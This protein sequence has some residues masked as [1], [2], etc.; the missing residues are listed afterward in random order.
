M[1]GCTPPPLPAG[2]DYPIGYTPDHHRAFAAAGT[3]AHEAPVTPIPEPPGF[4]K[5]P[6]GSDEP[7]PASGSEQIECRAAIRSSAAPRGAPRE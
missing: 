5:V 2:P 1:T 3:K 7:S 4:R 6:E